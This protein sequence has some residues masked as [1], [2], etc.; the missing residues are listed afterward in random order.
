MNKVFITYNDHSSWGKNT[1]L[2]MQTLSGLY[3]FEV[4]LPYRTGIGKITSETQKRIKTSDIVLVFDL[5]G[6]PSAVN[7]ELAYAL[8]VKKPVIIIQGEH[9]H[10]NYPNNNNI[11]TVRLN[12][13]N[14]DETLHE[15]ARYI[16]EKFNRQQKSEEGM[17]LALVSIGLGLLAYW[18]LSKPSK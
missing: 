4:D 10:L 12:Y 14:P 3:D 5:D 6:E 16:K 2:R 7:E 8:K 11:K 17:I 13:Y 15:I 18:A 9:P 1:A